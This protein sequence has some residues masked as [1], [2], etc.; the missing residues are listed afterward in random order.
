[1]SPPLL[2]ALVDFLIALLAAFIVMVNAPR[3]EA[4]NDTAA[5]CQLMVEAHWGDA[6]TSDVDLWV[7]APGDVP[8]GYS[9]KGSGRIF[10][11]L[12]DDLGTVS[13]PTNSNFEISCTRGLPDGEYAINVHLYRNTVDPYPI[14]VTIRATIRH[15]DTSS[16]D[17]INQAVSLTRFGEEITVVRF[18]VKDE[19]LVIGSKHRL[20]VELRSG[21]GLR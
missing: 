10:N 20:P 14:E 3:P 19:R 4:V 11:L 16:P 9:N 18:K 15:S 21:R 6:L 5:M 1:M 13:D 12:R 17:V 7:Q 2:T 8:V